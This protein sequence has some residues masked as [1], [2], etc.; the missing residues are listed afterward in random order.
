MTATRRRFISTKTVL[1]VYVRDSGLC[2]ICG[3]SVPVEATSIDHIIPVSL[4][5]DDDLSNL[6][7]THL[8]CNQSRGNGTRRSGRRIIPIGTMPESAFVTFTQAR[9][10]LGIASKDTLRRIIAREQWAVF[11]NPRDARE[12][13]LRRA[14]LEAYT[15][16][17]RIDQAQD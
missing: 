17:K 13:W 9:E 15:Q 10:L 14:D 16:P 3:D 8:T 2:G 1:A 7:L 11:N 12:R 6:R 4:G 5:G